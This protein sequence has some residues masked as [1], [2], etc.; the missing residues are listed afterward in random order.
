M[1]RK[2]SGEGDNNMGQH[3]GVQIWSLVGR[4]AKRFFFLEFALS[5]KYENFKSLKRRDNK[6]HYSC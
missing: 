1:K 6:F 3:G 5:E 2:L 4:A